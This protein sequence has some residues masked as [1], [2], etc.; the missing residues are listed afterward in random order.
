M[1]RT[2]IGNAENAVAP[3]QTGLKSLT[4]RAHIGLADATP[5]NPGRPSREKAM[6]SRAL[7]LLSKNPETSQKDNEQ[8]DNPDDD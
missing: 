8:D 5:S 7:K 6:H 1:I 4:P 3:L 2:H